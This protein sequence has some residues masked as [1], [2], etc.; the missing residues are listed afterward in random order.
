MRNFRSDCL[1]AM[2]G[3]LPYLGSPPQLTL[4][5]AVRALSCDGLVIRS[6]SRFFST[7]CFPPGAGPDYVNAVVRV[8]SRLSPTEMLD[9]M[10]AIEN[11]FSRTRETRWGMRTLDLD[12][13]AVDELILP[14]RATQRQWMTLPKAERSRIAPDQLILPHPRIQERAFVL[15]P[16]A[17]IAPDWVHPALGVNV[18]EMLARLGPDEIAAIRPL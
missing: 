16:L 4:R 18:R 12:L 5:Q 17:D 9:A 13:L 8:A 15:V 2:G 14:D 7:P 6:V 10:G 3:N 1:I 11:R